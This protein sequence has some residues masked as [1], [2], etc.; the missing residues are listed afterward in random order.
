MLT[1]ALKTFIASA[2]VA[3]T[4][5]LAT[6]TPASADGFS[7]GV[8]IGDGGIVVH[9]RGWDRRDRWDDRRDRG[10]HRGW[11]RHDDRGWRRHGRVQVCEPVWQK[12]KI[13]NQW[14]DVVRVIRYR[15]EEC[16][17]IRR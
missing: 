17:W 2:I 10:W 16:R 4:A 11:D 3:G 13:R 6:V 15:T 12:R 5:G 14:G 8:Q 1:N 9:D 7:F